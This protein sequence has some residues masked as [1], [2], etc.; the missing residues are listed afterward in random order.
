MAEEL[1]DHYEPHVASI[2]LVPSSGGLFE[3]SVDGSLIFSRA[4]LGRFP[5]LEELKAKLEALIP[6]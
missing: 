2:K 6:S 4:R 5:K 1:L 3:V